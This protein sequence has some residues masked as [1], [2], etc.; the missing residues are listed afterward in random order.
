ML[1]STITTARRD[2]GSSTKVSV[3]QHYKMPSSRT[4]NFWSLETY[5]YLRTM[6]SFC[7]LWFFL[8]L[9]CILDTSYALDFVPTPTLAPAQSLARAWDNLPT[10][11]A[12][13]F[14]GDLK[15]RSKSQQNPICGW[16]GGNGGMRDLLQMR[17]LASISNTGAER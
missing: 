8:F 3:L 12:G 15:G 4:G 13:S 11:T 14:H 16:I 10:I 6:P 17:N 5:I 2:W 1:Y 9:A 7:S